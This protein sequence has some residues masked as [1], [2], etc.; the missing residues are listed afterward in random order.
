MELYFKYN[1]LVNSCRAL[2]VFASWAVNCLGKA[3]TQKIKI[4]L[5]LLSEFPLFK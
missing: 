1:E 3:K 5:K 4:V 2:G